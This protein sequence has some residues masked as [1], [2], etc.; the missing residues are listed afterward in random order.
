MPKPFCHDH[1]DPMKRAEG[2]DFLDFLDFL[3]LH[4]EWGWFQKLSSFC[5]SFFSS[6]G[7]PEKFWK[8]I[9]CFFFCVS[10][11]SR[12]CLMFVQGRRVFLKVWRLNFLVIKVCYAS[13]PNNFKSWILKKSHG[14]VLSTVIKRTY[15]TRAGITRIWQGIEFFVVKYWY[16]VKSEANKP[17]R[18]E[19]LR[20]LIC[21]VSS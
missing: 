17:E 7:V 6:L 18:L 16:W 5:V 19:I 21:S 9:R 12:S 14:W 13:R 2:S 20:A 10:L 11:T 15:L 3:E 1:V 4:D 8:K